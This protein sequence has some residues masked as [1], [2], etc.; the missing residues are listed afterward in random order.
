[1]ALDKINENNIKINSGRPLSAESKQM[2]K[3][4][5]EQQKISKCHERCNK[6]GKDSCKSSRK[7]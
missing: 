1:M 5:E 4:Y 2:Q 7:Y 3:I 6:R